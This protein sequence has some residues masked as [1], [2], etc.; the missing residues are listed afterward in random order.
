MMITRQKRVPWSW[1]V[2]SHYPWAGMLFA[3]AVVT[4]IFALEMRKFTADPAIIGVVLTVTGVVSLIFEPLVNFL[5]DRIWTRWGRRKIFYVPSIFGQMVVI[6]C[7]PF[8]P[9]MSMLLGLMALH[10]TLISLSKPKESLVNEVVP[11]HQRGRGAVIHSVFVNIGLAAYNLALIGRFFDVNLRHP[12]DPWLGPSAGEK[13]IFFVFASALLSVVLIVSLGI[14]EMPPPRIGSLSDGLGIIKRWWQWPIRFIRRFFIDCFSSAWWPIYLL[15]L[16]QVL[17]GIGL[18]G[19]VALMYTDQWGYSTQDLG[20]NQ[21]IVQIASLLVIPL[22]LFYIIDRWDRLRTYALLIVVGMVMKLFWY[23]YV[24]LWVP[25]NRPEL[26]EIL[27]FGEGIAIVGMLAGTITYPLIYEFVPIDKMGTANAGLGLFRGLLGLVFGSAV[28]VWIKVVSELFLPAA[29]TTAV[30][31]FAEQVGEARMAEWVAE[32]DEQTGREHTATLWLPFGLE[33]ESGRQWQLHVA[34]PE[35]EA[36]QMRITEAEQSLVDHQRTMDTHLLLA[37]APTPEMLEIK[38]RLQAAL[39]AERDRLHQ[40]SQDLRSFLREQLGDQLTDP[41][42]AVTEA[43]VEVRR[44][45]ASFQLV[46]PLPEADQPR[47]TRELELKLQSEGWSEISVSPIDPADASRVTIEALAPDPFDEPPHADTEQLIRA[48]AWASGADAVER[49]ALLTD[50]VGEVAAGFRN[51]LDRPLPE[52]GYEPKRADYFSTYLFMA[53]T[54][55]VGLL[56]LG[57][58]ISLERRGKIVR[59]GALEDEH[60]NIRVPAS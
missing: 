8:A 26:W 7:I 12:L 29:G 3:S 30:V 35:A 9:N 5:S 46:Y 1:V 55:V 42:D 53:G 25:G 38:G 32:W 33:A 19:M 6:C 37:D 11:N 16:T 36:T 14:K 44:V 43:E 10:L 27:V 23:A 31:V 2:L 24:M 4:I 34:A 40:A 15:S 59:L 22:L 39:E 20:T 57:W 51:H 49:L 45:S 41:R 58:I 52:A 13:V 28:A 18:G 60:S 56:I 17:Y 47:L 54:D 21:G 50:A 48:G